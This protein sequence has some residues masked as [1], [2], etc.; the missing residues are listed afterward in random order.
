MTF[1]NKMLPKNYISNTKINCSSTDKK[2]L[3]HYGTLELNVRHAKLKEIHEI[4]S[5]KQSK[6]LEKY[7]NFNT[8]ERNQAVNY[9]E[10]Y[11]NKLLNNAF[12]G[13]TMEIA[14]NRLRLEII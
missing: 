11:F 13:K 7:I 14:G 1:M 5:F 3:I 8:Q 4:N 10:K 2:Y 12:Y 9:F 6:C